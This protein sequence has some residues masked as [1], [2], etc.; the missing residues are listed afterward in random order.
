MKADDTR[1]VA[2]LL[3][4]LFIAEGVHGVWYTHDDQNIRNDVD[5]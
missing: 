3:D 4:C 5:V 1:R 2:C